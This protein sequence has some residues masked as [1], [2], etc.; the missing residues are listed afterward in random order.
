MRYYDDI[1]L[2][3]PSA[4]S[5]AGYRLYDDSDLERLAFVR[6]A[7]RLGC[8]LGEVRELVASWDAERCGVVQ[9]RL[10]DVVT[11]EA[12]AVEARVGEL[13]TLAIELHQAAVALDVAP[14][15]GP[16]GDGC[17]CLGHEVGSPPV[18]CTLGPAARADRVADWSTVLGSSL[19]RR[20]TARGV[21]IVLDPDVDLAELGRL[22]DAERACCGFL[23][24]TLTVEGARMVLDV[25]A[26]DDARELVGALFGP[27]DV[28]PI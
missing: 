28:T 11:A 25:R 18:A 13:A 1:G 2:V 22:L 14:A 10:H 16:C 5:A 3:R 23:G 20:A 24:F 15:D 21:R 7:K 8:S 4:R 12:R 27:L 19:D 9:R 17:V 26:P 6:R